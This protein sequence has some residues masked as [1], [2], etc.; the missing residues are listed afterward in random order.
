MTQNNDI[1]IEQW[2]KAHGVNRSRVDGCT[3]HHD[4]KRELF[5]LNDDERTGY[6]AGSMTGVRVTH[7][8]WPG[9]IFDLDLSGSG[10]VLAMSATLDLEARQRGETITVRRLRDVPLANMALAARAAFAINNDGGP[11]AD[12][13]LPLRQHESG[14]KPI[15]D[16]RLAQAMVHYIDA[17]ANGGSTKDAAERSHV[18]T[19]TMNSYRNKAKSR[20]IFVTYG[21]GKPGG[22]LTNKGLA[23][24]K[25]GSE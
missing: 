23:F 22:F 25:E 16:H 3:V 2:L 20:G 13:G 5:Y 15:S 10:G 21:R 4:E 8:D 24:L 17:V 14:P 1:P 18:S 9:W 19:S 7:K 6:Q 12:L 11:F